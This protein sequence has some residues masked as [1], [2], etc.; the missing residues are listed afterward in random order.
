MTD[1][2][3]TEAL[4]KAADQHPRMKNL[5]PPWRKGLSPN[6]G[7]L[8]R[9]KR[10]HTLYAEQE[11]ALVAHHGRALTARETLLLDELINLKLRKLKELPDPV[12]RANSL[13]RL[14]RALY[15][16]AKPTPAAVVPLRERLA[17]EAEAEA[18]AVAAKD[19]PP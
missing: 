4:S 9:G 12:K 11:A 5:R 3:L 6:P 10:Y 19:V 15:G 14:L 16:A 17:R 8:Q 7:G 13:D 2:A 18:S 1:L